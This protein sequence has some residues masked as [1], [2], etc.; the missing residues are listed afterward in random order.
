RMNAEGAEGAQRNAEA[1]WDWPLRG[2][3]GQRGGRACGPMEQ[4]PGAPGPICGRSGPV[5]SP[6]GAAIRAN[7]RKPGSVVQLGGSARKVMLRARNGVLRARSV[8][9]R[10]RSAML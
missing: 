5:L 10:A 8:M 3:S 2:F 4:R 6:V 7:N 9:L 1:R